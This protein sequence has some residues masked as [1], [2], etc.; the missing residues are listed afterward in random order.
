MTDFNILFTGANAR[1]FCNEYQLKTLKKEPNCFKDCIMP[2]C[3]DFHIKNCL[4]SFERTL[5][6]ETDPS[7]FYKLIHCVKCL[8]SE[9]FWSAFSR[10]WTE[11][12]EIRSYTFCA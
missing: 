3:I 9:L 2:S 4:K 1:A 10:I 5:T 7:D 8:Y 12:E 11:Y 6:M